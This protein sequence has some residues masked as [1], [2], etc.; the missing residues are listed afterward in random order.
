MCCD[1]PRLSWRIFK[2]STSAVCHRLPPVLLSLLSTGAALVS[3]SVAAKSLLSSA[4]RLKQSDL[5]IQTPPVRASHQRSHITVI[6]PES[7]LRDG[8]IGLMG[9]AERGH[10]S[11]GNYTA[12]SH[13]SWL[14]P[15]LTLKY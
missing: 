5:H 14:E 2:S 10:K 12:F 1:F 4:V 3:T 11:L 6:K 15:L 13:K 8:L 9:S 7:D